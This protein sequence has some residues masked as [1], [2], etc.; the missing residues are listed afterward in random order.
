MNRDQAELMPVTLDL[1][2]V[3]SYWRLCSHHVAILISGWTRMG[4]LGGSGT[5]SLRV[6]GRQDCHGEPKQ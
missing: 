5:G 6:S 2:T 3:E 1:R 4:P